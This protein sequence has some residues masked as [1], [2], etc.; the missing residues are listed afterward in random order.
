MKIAD[1][2]NLPL[3]KIAIRCVPPDVAPQAPELI[4]AVFRIGHELLSAFDRKVLHVI[5]LIMDVAMSEKEAEFTRADHDVLVEA[6]HMG[7]GDII[8]KTLLEL[9]PVIRTKGDLVLHKGKLGTVEAGVF[10]GDRKMRVGIHADDIDPLVPAVDNAFRLQ[11]IVHPEHNLGSVID[12]VDRIEMREFFIAERGI[13]PLDARIR[14]KNVSQ[15]IDLDPGLLKGHVIGPVGLRAN[16]EAIFNHL[17]IMSAAGIQLPT[18]SGPAISD[19]RRDLHFVIFERHDEAAVTV[20]AENVLVVVAV[21]DP[22]GE[23]VEL[24]STDIID[25]VL[26]DRLVLE[27]QPYFRHPFDDVLVTV[28]FLL[29]VDHGTPLLG[30]ARCRHERMRLHLGAVFILEE[31]LEDIR[32]ISAVIAHDDIRIIVKIRPVPP[33]DPAAVTFLAFAIRII[34]AIDVLMPGSGSTL[35]LRPVELD[36]ALGI[37]AEF[38]ELVPSPAEAAFG[39]PVGVPFPGQVFIKGD[40]LRKFDIRAVLFPVTCGR[41]RT[42]QFSGIVR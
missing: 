18:V 42:F 39:A 40:P 34:L 8:L 31:I 23:V 3:L 6:L 30:V 19:E 35:V 21:A 2:R 1:R 5:V 15:L 33:R 29:D 25:P 14:L 13:G 26:V 12:H 9:Q 20:G 28:H 41:E 32:V 36:V 7:P 11:A 10:R 37:F 38:I 16:V 24:E 22:L 27:V 4:D 17:A